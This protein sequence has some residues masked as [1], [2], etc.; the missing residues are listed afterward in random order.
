MHPMAILGLY[1]G[2]RADDPRR[3]NSEN[4]SQPAKSAGIAK[5]FR[6]RKNRTQAKQEPGLDDQP[7]VIES[8]APQTSVEV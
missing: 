6:I 7:W 5:L 3:R 2:T 8:K 1:R 4:V